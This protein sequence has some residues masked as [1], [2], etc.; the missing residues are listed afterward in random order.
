MICP[1]CG[2]E[3]A[4]LSAHRKLDA[5]GD[6]DYACA[7]SGTPDRNGW[8]KCSERMP[9]VASI[10]LVWREERK[11][12][13]WAILAE[14]NEWRGWDSRPLAWE[15]FYPTHW[16]PLPDPPEESK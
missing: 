15:G 13:W 14:E 2:K 11:M 9:D 4:M 1:S 3:V 7:R 10:V 16:Q 12:A 5:A 8:I 6:S